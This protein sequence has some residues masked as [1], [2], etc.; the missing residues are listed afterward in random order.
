MTNDYLN[1]TIN[2]F[3]AI[4]AVLVLCIAGAWVLV[5]RELKGIYDSKQK[6]LALLNAIPEKLYRNCLAE[7][8]DAL[9]F[10]AVNCY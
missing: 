2:I 10:L 6:H 9:F 4:L 5:V 7:Y 1:L 8:K 3:K